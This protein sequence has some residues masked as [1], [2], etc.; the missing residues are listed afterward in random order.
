MEPLQKAWADGKVTKTEARQVERVILQIR[1]EA[2]KRDE[3]EAFAQAIKIAS[4]AARTFELT[5][6]NLPTIPFATR[7]KSRTKRGAY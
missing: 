1:K 4:Q 3:E 5:R 7:I 6:P 2:A